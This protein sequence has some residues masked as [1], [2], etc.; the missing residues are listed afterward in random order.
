MIGTNRAARDRQDHGGRR[1]RGNRPLDS[2]LERHGRRRR[3][4]RRR[5]RLL[6][7]GWLRGVRKGFPFRGGNGFARRGG[8]FLGRAFR[9][10]ERFALR[11]FASIAFGGGDRFALGG[12]P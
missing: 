11:G 1:R 5:G 3:R 12:R 6:R 8:S 4:R 10:R 9:R 2:R 7:D